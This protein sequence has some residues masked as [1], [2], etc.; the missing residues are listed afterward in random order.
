MDFNDKNTFEVIKK[1][2]NSNVYRSKL[3]GLVYKEVIEDKIWINNKKQNEFKNLV[4]RFQPNF[5]IDCK[6]NWYSMPFIEGEIFSEYLEKN[7]KNLTDDEINS[8]CSH[9]FEETFKILK[10]TDPFCI[11]N[12]HPDQ[13]IY[14]R[15]ENKFTLLDW[16]EFDLPTPCTKYELTNYSQSFF[17]VFEIL[18]RHGRWIGLIK[19]PRFEE[20]SRRTTEYLHSNFDHDETVLIISKFVDQID[21]SRK[22]GIPLSAPLKILA[23][24]E[25]N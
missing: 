24:N 21:N 11:A 3:N 13:W 17:R 18:Q 5:I 22:L 16:D 15:K 2:V 10:I 6:D 9:Y 12:T 4:N 14:N 1:H 7:A 25:N 19:L 8:I 20:F 23:D